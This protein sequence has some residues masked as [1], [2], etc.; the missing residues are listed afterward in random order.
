MLDPWYSLEQL[1]FKFRSLVQSTNVRKTSYLP[2]VMR[3]YKKSCNTLRRENML[4][5]V[6]SLSER[7][8]A[9]TPRPQELKYFAGCK[10][11]FD[12]P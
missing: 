2:L 10:K 9:L 6:C 5:I 11:Q 7:I 8:F 1:R 12:Q 3:H 4:M